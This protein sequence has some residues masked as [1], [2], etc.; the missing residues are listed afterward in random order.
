VSNLPAV[1]AGEPS[2]KSLAA[3]VSLPDEDGELRLHHLLAILLHS[4]WLILGCVILALGIAV[5][6]T[7]F[8]QPIYQAK[9]TVRI[10]AKTPS[11]P[12]V[13]PMLP[14]GSEVGTEMEVIASRR[15]IED[16][17]RQLGLQLRVERPLGVS[18]EDLLDQVRISEDA[19]ARGLQLQRLADDRFVATDAETGEVIGQVG[20]GERLEMP[21]AGFRLLP[22]ASRHPVIEIAITRFRS[23]VAMV[24]LGMSVERAGRE[25]DVVILSYRDPDPGLVWRVPNAILERF[26]ER[27]QEM[28]K[29]EARSQVKFL[30][31]QLDTLNRQLGE[32]EEELKDFRERAQVVSPMVEA[33]SRIQRLV[34][35]EAERS[36]LNAERAALAELL[37]KVDAER[38]DQQE[39]KPSPYRQLLAFPSL[40][41]SEA[42]SQLLRSLTEVEDQ[43]SALLAR[44]TSADAD[45]Q[46]LTGR[47]QELEEQL[48]TIGRTYLNGLTSQVASLD[49]T[50]NR[51][52]SELRSMPQKELEYG[53]LERRPAVLKEIYTLLQTRLKEAEIAQAVDDASVTIV[54]E[55]I[56]SRSPITPKKHLAYL[57]GLFGGLVLGVGV[58]LGRELLDLSVRT[59]ADVISATGLP[60]LALIPRIGHR[61][62]QSAMIAVRS[63]TKQRLKAKQRP[64]SQQSAPPPMSPPSPPTPLAPPPVRARPTYTFLASTD[65]TESDVIASDA[66]AA[67]VTPP[68]NPAAAW[69]AQIAHDNARSSQVHLTLSELGSAMAEAY[70]ILQTNLAFARLEDPVK[71]LVLTSALPGEGKTTTAVNLAI[72]LTHRG[73][74]VLLIDADLRKGQVHN[75]FGIPRAPGL[76]DVLHG[77]CDAEIARRVIALEGGRS[78]SLLT[79]GAPE[80][81]PPALVGSSRMRNL[82][83]QVRDLYNL[84]IVDSPPVNILTDAALLGTH[85]DGVVLV[86]RAGATDSS[87]LAYAVE[88]LGHVRAPVLGVVLND[89]DLK[90]HGTYDGAYRYVDYKS[91]LGSAAGNE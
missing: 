4:R 21:G 7:R 50:L 91:Y 72:A 78:L 73:L 51:F 23:A 12:R 55:A 30:R 8:T 18:R 26:I 28:Q 39:G 40:L 17:T 32:S 49:A 20:P 70:S 69:I 29:T 54:D 64:Q 60:V 77:R 58:A 1:R 46:L 71:T 42:A 2:G 90:R 11:L 48:A 47:I 81:S 56:P 61:G 15:L 88:Q 13:F 37:A 89:I 14:Q 10:D 24:S 19:R 53:R 43:R 65:E 62:R 25:A 67:P 35:L 27:R 86:A 87:A 31:A 59:R 80:N 68:A 33:Q 57:M 52:S 82:L 75:L 66:S 36:T 5:A 76:T 41:R 38:A 85:A 74:N 6:Y 3:R 45:V 63:L 84:V 16:A 9:A 83:G 34:G 44:R 22:G 79:C